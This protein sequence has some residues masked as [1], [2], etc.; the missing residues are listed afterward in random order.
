MGI[1]AVAEQLQTTLAGMQAR[2]DP[3]RYFLAV[4]L[5]VT[6]AIRAELTAGGFR[7]PDWVDRWDAVFASLYLD[8]VARADRSE[9]VPGPWAVAFAAD[10]QPPVRQVLLGMNAHIN[11]DMPQ[12][13]L[14]V[15]PAAEFA[16]PE[17]LAGRQAD[18]RRIDA[19][20]ARRVTAEGD[21]A[22]RLGRIGR[23][24]RLLRP[25]NERATRRF[26]HEAREKV[27]TN[28]VRLDTARS[29]GPE[30]LAYRLG[31]LERLSTGRLQRLCAPGPVLLALAVGGFGVVLPPT[32]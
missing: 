4:Y 23:T 30:Q 17:R 25:L 31:E 27:W 15:L 2:A 16:D 32:R 11:Y 3:R 29:R 28:A 20:L 12:A 13:L 7:D 14:A 24:D 1:D 9:P 21:E 18:H 26:L 19:V 5:R 8:A 10:R 6:L 22:E